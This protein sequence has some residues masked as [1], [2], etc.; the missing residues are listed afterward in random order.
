MRT[1]AHYAAWEQ[2]KPQWLYALYGCQRLLDFMEGR[3]G[4]RERFLV[5]FWI[6]AFLSSKHFVQSSRDSKFAC[7]TAAPWNRV[8]TLKIEK[9][10]LSMEKTL[11]RF[12]HGKNR[13]Q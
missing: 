4:N 2:P 1:F 12:W 5:V 10:V 11:K 3:D 8:R 13:E 9:E 7:S 6:S